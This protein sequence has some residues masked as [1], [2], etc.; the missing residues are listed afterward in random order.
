MPPLV[1]T[2]VMPSS[3]T[4]IPSLDEIIKLRDRHVVVVFVEKNETEP[5]QKK[6]GIPPAGKTSHQKITARTPTS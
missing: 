3:I 6:I 1:M 5:S 2:M 4:A